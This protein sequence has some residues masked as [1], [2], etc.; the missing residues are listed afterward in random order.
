M[1]PN[2][3]SLPRTL[4]SDRSGILGTVGGFAAG[5]PPAAVG[6]YLGARLVIPVLLILF[7]GRGATP[8]QR[9]ALVRDHLAVDAGQPAQG[10]IRHSTSAGSRRPVW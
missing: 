3:T 4:A 9:I 2:L 5:L 6:C 1:S 10:A 8:A 7:A